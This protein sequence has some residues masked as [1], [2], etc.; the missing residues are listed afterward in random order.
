VFILSHHQSCV[1][2][3]IYLFIYLYFADTVSQIILRRIVGYVKN[4]LEEAFVAYFRYFTVLAWR[5]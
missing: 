4:K 5:N 2:P 3:S 1:V